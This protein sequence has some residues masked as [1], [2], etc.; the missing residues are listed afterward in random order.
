MDFR[1]SRLFNIS[2]KT[3][4]CFILHVLRSIFTFYFRRRNRWALQEDSDVLCLVQFHR[5]GDGRCG[6]E[7][8]FS[9][10]QY[11]LN[12]TDKG[13]MYACAL[14]FKRRNAEARVDSKGGAAVP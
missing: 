5:D 3:T 7:W 13:E 8:G 1:T 14:I 10:I 12:P 4:N 9:T 6:S 2:R 11:R